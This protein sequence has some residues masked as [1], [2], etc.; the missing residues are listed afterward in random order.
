MRCF[1]GSILPMYMLIIK[2]LNRADQLDGSFQCPSLTVAAEYGL[3]E[4]PHWAYVTTI[5]GSDS[6]KASVAEGRFVL[7]PERQKREHSHGREHYY[8]NLQ[9]SVQTSLLA[10]RSI[11]RLLGDDGVDHRHTTRR[12]NRVR[13]LLK[14]TP[15]LLE[16]SRL[17]LEHY[18]K[19][20]NYNGI[21]SDRIQGIPR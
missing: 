20:K 12:L 17:S 9:C 4:W 14:L 3:A 5:T 15:L 7:A 18:R 11:R 10:A 8:H 6:A 19:G 2:K 1:G 13:W 16:T 21:L